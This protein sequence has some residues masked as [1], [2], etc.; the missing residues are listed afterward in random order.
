MKPRLDAY[1]GWFLTLEGHNDISRSSSVV[2]IT[3]MAFEQF[4]VSK[5]SLYR[6]FESKDALIAAF[7]AERDRSF[8]AWWDHI[9]EQHA[10]DPRV[11]LD[12]L[13][14]GIAERIGRRAYRACPFL[15][16]TTEFPDQNHPGRI[17]ARGNKEELRARLTTIVAK[18]GAADPNRV[19]FQLALIIN[20]AYATS[21]IAEPADLK[22]D[23]VDAAQAVGLV[24]QEEPSPVF[25]RDKDTGTRLVGSRE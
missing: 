18:L 10:G 8:W 2:R 19:G 25:Y 9:E 11:L 6:A 22:G 24:C 7:A 3:G 20:G 15:N 12:A 1:G 4:G 21:L 13:L 5:T 14:S 16:L 17:V 23:L